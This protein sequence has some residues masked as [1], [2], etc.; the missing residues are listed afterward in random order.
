MLLCVRLLLLSAVVGEALR[1]SPGFAR[2]AARSFSPTA[3]PASPPRRLRPPYLTLVASSCRADC[4]T[5][6]CTSK[7]HRVLRNNV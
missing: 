3:R 7:G 1:A 5:F 2:G 4:S 6:P